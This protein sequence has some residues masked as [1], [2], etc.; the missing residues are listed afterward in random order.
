MIVLPLR[1]I[2]SV[3]RLAVRRSFRDQLHMTSS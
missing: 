1:D 3:L 2:V